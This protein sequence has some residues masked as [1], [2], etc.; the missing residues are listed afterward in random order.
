MTEEEKRLITQ[1]KHPGRVAKGHKLA[2]LMKKRKEEI[3]RNKEQSTVQS[4]VQSSVQSTE[5]FSVQSNDTYV[6]GVDILAVL[7]IGFVYF[8][9]ITPLGLKIK[10]P[11]MKNKVSHQNYLLCFRKMLIGMADAFAGM[12]MWSDLIKAL[13]NNWLVLIGKKILKAIS[14]MD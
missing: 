1:E 13:Y 5:Q 8:L 11:S 7:A 14:R 9:H 12:E 6:N 2:A 10:K 3:L 4:T